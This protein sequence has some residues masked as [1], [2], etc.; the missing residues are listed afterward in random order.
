MKNILTGLLLLTSASSFAATNLTC[1][2]F[3]DSAIGTPVKEIV[4]DLDKTQEYKSVFTSERQTFT[5]TVSS[6]SVNLGFSD[7]N[8]RISTVLSIDIVRDMQPSQSIGIISTSNDKDKAYTA[9]CYQTGNSTTGPW[10]K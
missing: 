3:K 6:E 4:L 2:I 1:G 7:T 8:G 9:V 10:A 5:V